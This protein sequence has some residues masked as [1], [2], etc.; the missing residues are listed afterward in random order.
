MKKMI[1]LMAALAFLGSPAL[2]VRYGIKKQI[3][4]GY[5][6]AAPSYLCYN[7]NNNKMYVGNVGAN[8]VMAMSCAEDSMLGAVYG[9]WG[10][11]PMVYDS[12]NNR[13]YYKDYGTSFYA[14]DCVSDTADTSFNSFQNNGW[15]AYNPTNDKIYIDDNFNGQ[16]LVVNASDYSYN[17]IITDWT[18]PTH[19]YAPTNSVYIPFLSLGAGAMDSLGVFSGADESKIT[20]IYVPTMMDSRK[21]MSS[22]PNINRL[23]ITLDAS[24]QVAVINTATNSLVI[25]LPVGDNPYSFA[26]CPLNDRMFVAC[27][28][29]SQYSLKY[30]DGSDMVDSVSVGDSVST[31]VYNPVDSLIYIGCNSSGYVKLVDPRLPVPAVID[32]VYF[33]AN[34]N[35]MDLSVDDGGDVYCA[36]A[37][38]DNIYVIGQIPRRIWHTVNSGMWGD[39]STWDYSD[40]G[41]ASWEGNIMMFTPDCAADSLVTIDSTH[42]VTIS[43]QA[44]YLDQVVVKSGA[45]LYL[46]AQ[47]TLGDTT[48]YDLDVNGT[49][50]LS[51]SDFTQS[52]QIRF[53]PYSQ[54]IHGLDGDT[55]PEADWD[56]LSTINLLGITTTVPVGLNKAFGT[57]TWD[58]ASQMSNLVLAG[59]AGFSCRN[60]F[61]SSTG[62]ARMIICSTTNPTVNIPG[63]LTVNTGA[64]VLM[65]TTGT[66]VVSVG[67]TFSVLNSGQFYISD[68]SYAAIDTLVLYGNY[69]HLWTSVHGGL[70]GT[71]TM[72]FDGNRVHT[73]YGEIGEMYGCVDIVVR[74]GST[75]DVLQNATVG[76]G[77]AGSFTLMAGAT[78]KV[79]DDAGFYATGT[80]N[81]AIRVSGARNYSKQAN[82][83][84]CE[85]PGGYVYSGDGLPDTVNMLTID[86]QDISLPGW[87]QEYNSITVT[88]T[89]ALLN[90][91]IDANYPITINGPVNWGSGYINGSVPITVSGSG[92]D[93]VLPTAAGITLP[94]LTIDRPGRTVDLPQN[95]NVSDTLYL[96]NGSI[97]NTGW[98][99]VLAVNNGATVQRTNGWV[100]GALSKYIDIGTANLTYELGADSGY[101]PVDMLFGSVTDPEY[102]TISSLDS[103]AAG[104]DLPANCLK[105][106]W[107]LNQGNLLGF[108]GGT[109]TF[110]YLPSDFNTGLLEAAD[111]TVLVAGG[112]NNSFGGWE[113]QD[114][115]ARAAGGISDGGTIEIIGLTA[116][117]IAKKKAADLQW[118]SLFTLAKNLRALQPSKMWRLAYDS[119]TSIYD[120]NTG[121]W[122]TSIDGGM[123]WGYA[124][125]P[126]SFPTHL[127]STIIIQ[128]WATVNINIDLTVDEVV[129]SGI[130]NLN[131]GVLTIADNSGVD[132]DFNIIGT[133]FRY[134]GTLNILGTLKVSGGGYYEHMV[135]GGD[136]PVASWDSLSVLYIRGVTDSAPSGMD[137]AFGDIIWE[138][139]NQSADFVLPGGASFGAHDISVNNTS[140]TL[141]VIHTLCLT[142]AAKP[143]VTIN[144]LQIANSYV[145][146]GAGGNRNLHVKGGL[147]VYDP[148][149]LYLTDTLSPGIDTLFL[150][151]DYSHTMAGIRGGGPDSTTIVFCGKGTQNYSGSSEILSGYINY[152]V[153]AGSF[154]KVQEWGVLGSGSQG[155]FTLMSG[156]TLGYCDYW[157]IYSTG[158]DTGVIRNGG[159]RNYSQGANYYIYGTSTGPYATGPGM[160]DTVNQLIVESFMDQA[161]LSKDLAVMDT[162]KLLNNTLRIN[163]RRLSLFGEIYIDMGDMIGDS[164]TQLAVMGGNTLRV[165]LPVSLTQLSL[166]SV[167]RPA[168]VTM[169]NSLVIY[170]QLDLINGAL[171]NGGYPLSFWDGISIYRTPS[172]S[173]VGLSP[174]FMGLVNVTYG[175]GILTS[176]MELPGGLSSNLN[177]LT[178]EG[179]GDTVTVNDSIAV[180]DTL[181]LAGGLTVNGDFIF[182]YRSVDTLNSPGLLSTAP[183]TTIHLR[184]QTFPAYLPRINGGYLNIDSTSGATMGGDIILSGNIK[185]NT[186]PLTISHYTLSLADS[187]MG[188]GG[189]V[190]DSSSSLVIYGTNSGLS[191][192]SG[193]SSLK[194][195]TLDN[196]SG[197]ALSTAI[198]IYG[199]YTQTQGSLSGSGL[200]Y[201]GKGSLTYNGMVPVLA[202]DLEFPAASGPFSLY[203]ENPAGV[204]V[205]SL[206]LLSGDLKILA[207]DTLNCVT[208]LVVAGNIG[209][210]G[211]QQGAGY[212]MVDNDAAADTITGTG[213]FSNLRIN[214]A[215]ETWVMDSV[216]IGQNL[217]L[218]IFSGNTNGWFKF[219]SGATIRRDGGSLTAVQN[220]TNPI[221]VIYGGNALTTGNELPDSMLHDLTILLSNSADSVILAKDI[222]L[223]SLFLTNGN[224]SVGPRTM[225][226]EQGIMTAS[227]A[228][229]TDSTSTLIVNG[230][231]AV[232]L[233]ASAGIVKNI[234]LS[235]AGG[236]L[237]FGGLNVNDTLGIKDG[238]I[239]GD[240][241]TNYVTYG[242]NGTLIYQSATAA[243]ITSDVTY[244][245]SSGLKN[246]VIDNLNGVTLHADRSVS[247]SL[248]LVNGI[249][250]T[251]ANTIRVDSTGVMTAAGGW[252]DGNLTKYVVA[253]AS[254]DTFT[255]GSANG[256]SMA[257]LSFSNVSSAGYL[258]VSA[259]NATHPMVDSANYCMS[260]YWSFASDSSLTFDSCNVELGYLSSDFVPSYFDEAVYENTM[261]AGLYDST[262]TPPWI[263]PA[264]GIRNV[265]TTS[266]GGS[267]QLTGITNLNSQMTLA[268]DMVYISKVPDTVAPFIASSTPLDAAVGVGFAD[269]VRITFS[270]PVKKS[271]VSYSFTPSPATLDTFWSADSTSII[272]SHSDLSSLTAYTVKVIGVQD[273]AAN[274][275]SGPDS[276]TFT[277]ISGD[278]TA[279]FIAAST[280]L[281]GAVGVGFTDSVRITFSEPV[282]KSL[283]TYSFTPNPGT[284]DTVWSIDSTAVVFSHSNFAELTSYI[285]RVTNVQDTVGNLLTG[286]DSIAFATMVAPDTIGPYISFTQPFNGQTGVGLAE[287]VMISFN[288]A[289]DT[290]SLRF[291]CAPDPGGW[292]Q[293]WNVNSQ[294][295]Y[296]SHNTFAPGVAYSFSV[297]SLRDTSGNQLRSDTLG[298][299]NPWSFTIVPN[300]TSSY[301]W[302]GGAYRLVSLPLV[303]ADTTAVGNFGDD[304]GAYSDT[305]WRMF[306]YKTGTGYIEN[307]KIT[308]GYGYWMASSGDAS[309]DVIGT[310]PDQFV[311]VPVDSGWN[312]IGMPF[313]TVLHLTNINVLW[314]DSLSHNLRYDSTLVNTVF[315]Q[316]LWSW[317][318]LSND[319]VNDDGVWDS[320]TPFNPSDS[321][322]RWQGYAAYAVRPCT[323]QISPLGSKNGKI[324]PAPDGQIDW[325]LSLDVISGQSADRGMRLGVSAQAAEKYDRLD[326]EKPPLITGSIKAYFPHDDWEQG[327]CRAYQYDFRPGSEYIEWPLEVEMAAQDRQAV[328]KYQLSGVLGSD[329]KLYLIDR[330]NFKTTVLSAKG[331]LGFSGSQELSVI[332]SNKGPGI[333]SFKPLSLALASPYPNPFGQKAVISYQLPNKGPVTLKIYN[334]GGQLVK[335]LVNEISPPGYYTVGWDG[336]DHAGSR[337]SSGVYIARLSAGGQDLVQK[338][339]KVR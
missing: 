230:T 256:L 104:V 295:V 307:P 300:D 151:G 44:E 242:S 154:L 107:V 98:G 312:I 316:R 171:D 69:Q 272:F 149:W 178:V 11:G 231:S 303:S 26:L 40:N 153:N 79:R 270:E 296:L 120:W 299:A 226:F 247:N 253:G 197:L 265:G 83:Y 71:A 202:S 189:L 239:Y 13:V 333:Y 30:I 267:I 109:A 17:P 274:M 241:L 86:N 54:Y 75:L 7:K 329:Y 271:L 161:Y 160:P 94:T 157:G 235:N 252:V 203:I 258:N 182:L 8:N 294:L 254:S 191:V 325:Q 277:T 224:L 261:A 100:K 280:P 142:S 39:Y 167:N 146:L 222:R 113:L 65:G 34:S 15:C 70:P 318:D 57:V 53:G 27:K 282:R 192:P 219:I 88:D 284:V 215:L 209:N 148:A 297:D 12:V 52:G 50:M 336:H 3:V 232:E 102:L 243:Q 67:G 179:P 158:K 250:T 206:R 214:D 164:L 292:S 260:R 123:T 218:D 293:S 244:S 63:D 97:N 211:V 323:L 150:Y 193:I 276:I 332:Y 134:G 14:I 269:S 131:S 290:L 301:A 324:S 184:D 208:G 19:Y 91:F 129:D 311:T 43:G 165:T 32:S 132:P 200:S 278:T 298:V 87:Y 268:R 264:I 187:V 5:T 237:L 238:D 172:C 33:P 35:F 314:T 145:V 255:V 126:D 305:T 220:F 166:L 188:T 101:T 41:G 287:Q 152:Q 128:P 1:V 213:S 217:Y 259:T 286:S 92:P 45:A 135:N 115:G 251:G 216:T 61:V 116:T 185:T 105:R 186:S 162:L 229:L 246:L 140:D 137:Q 68:S 18:G 29:T 223:D 306:G 275:L 119:L 194:N 95:V 181:T 198:N 174:T 77:S 302:S 90:G 339:V 266:D 125:Y 288:E 64:T 130:V 144:S 2:A 304:L 313:D 228:L 136:I 133:F 308:N 9:T 66:N 201:T 143:E 51:A 147:T 20:A 283:M 233:P 281:D 190:S 183:A 205:D 330:K 159:A 4:T 16:T 74:P 37:N 322:R 221:N 335:T 138:C 24:G 327:P 170:N 84:F 99:S 291:T 309:L 62:L 338:L 279:P 240:T 59:E 328:L 114:I 82:Y 25:S 42:V 122:E 141:G 180:H 58:G 204:T 76:S 31:V 199:M 321:L 169:S 262:A 72:A 177:R 46:Q 10:P 118:T 124:S 111:E 236:L 212:I 55:I 227:G 320:L 56:S 173:L 139:A 248:Q 110:S 81:G 210:D 48:G 273:T 289:V 38:Y 108:S 36:I 263:Y 93:I 249:L 257:A 89:L 117:P 28:G 315:R 337:V 234:F 175:G 127:D 168:S 319:L 326:A 310:P 155:D 156:A 47:T 49:L 225:T 176:G 334:I 207:G 285:V 317:N 112:Y 60:L 195:L 80:D 96:S 85:G 121:P 73:Y 23:Y 103:T 6:G 21:I 331:E 106:H 78:L 163:G 22:N 245:L 196:P